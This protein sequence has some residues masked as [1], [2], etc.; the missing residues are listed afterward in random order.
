MLTESIS[1]PWTELET[2]CW[3]AEACSSERILPSTMVS[4]TPALAWT[5][6]LLSSMYARFSPGAMVT[7]A[8]TTSGKFRITPAIF[9]SKS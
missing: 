9:C 8:S 1:S 5:T 2:N 3:M 6:L 7:V 4:M